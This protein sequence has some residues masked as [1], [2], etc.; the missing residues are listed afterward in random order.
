MEYR[1]EVVKEKR[2]KRLLKSAVK[3]IAVI[4]VISG[5]F[6]A[7]IGV[8]SGNIVLGRDAV[9]HKSVQK[10]APANLNYSSVE[11]VYDTLRQ[12]YD[13]QLDVNKLLDGLKTG[14]TQAT[15]D[16]YTEYFNAEDAKKLEEQLTGSFTGIGA[17]LGKDADK[18][19]VVISPIAGFP[20]DKAGLKA[21]DIIVE[22]D[23]ASTANMTISQAVS[24]IRGPKDT[25][26]TLKIVRAGS[27]QLSLTITRDE[28]T[29]PSVKSDVLS[30]SI[31]YLQIT[32]FSKDTTQL[33]TDAANKFKQAGVKGVILDLRGDPG[34]YLDSAVDISG[35][36]LDSGKT[37]LTERRDGTIVQTY[38]TRG[39]PILRGIPTVVLI[40]EGSASAS[41]IM[42]GALRDNNVA[43]LIGVTSFGKGS[44]QQV[45][46][47]PGGAEL[48]VTIAR[49]Y[50]PNGKN[51]DKQGIK[52]DQEVKLTEDDFRAG[53]DPQKDAALNF[54]K[55]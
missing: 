55:K 45:V 2:V 46:E 47:L 13:G 29:V 6:W 24:K 35:L 30:G 36:W 8:G 14:L 23:G 17:E 42:A 21:K 53:R 22:V 43:T 12:S 40:D 20:A 4:S 49:W 11:Q 28:I 34:G 27:Q 26:V 44:V 15:D 51:I 38:T 32:Q 3:I 9:F 16:P 7:G 25:K 54:L 18:N 37:V 48:K 1:V 52:P 41:E 10:N 19:L 5:V 31:G 33:A 50:T 39:T